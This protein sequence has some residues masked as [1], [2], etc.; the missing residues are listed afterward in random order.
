M[1]GRASQ[2]LVY[3]DM[4]EYGHSNGTVESSSIRVAKYTYTTRKADAVYRQK[5][6]EDRVIITVPWEKGL[7]HRNSTGIGQT[8][9]PKPKGKP[10]R[11][12]Q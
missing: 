4:T 11:K 9:N 1:P 6:I 10:E 5:Y 3:S 12:L 7:V 2:K 8:G